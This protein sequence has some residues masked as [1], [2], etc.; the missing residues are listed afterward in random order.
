[1]RGVSARARRLT[2]STRPSRS[3]DRGSTHVGAEGEAAGAGPLPRRVHQRPR[4]AAPGQDGQPVQGER[5]DDGVPGDAQDADQDLPLRREGAEFGRDVGEEEADEEARAGH[6]A[7]DEQR[8]NDGEVRPVLGQRL[9]Q[10]P[11]V[12]HQGV[13]DLAE[14]AEAGELDAPQRVARPAEGG[15]RQRANRVVAGE[16]RDVVEEDEEVEFLRLRQ[17]RVPRGHAVPQNVPQE[18]REGGGDAH[19]L[20]ERVVLHG[21]VRSVV[22]RPQQ[23]DGKRRHDAAVAVIGDEGRPRRQCVT[24]HASFF[25]GQHGAVQANEAPEEE[26]DPNLELVATVVPRCSPGIRHL[27]PLVCEVAEPHYWNVQ[28]DKSP[29]FASSR[30]S[31]ALQGILL[32]FCMMYEHYLIILRKTLG[33]VDVDCPP[34]L[35]LPHSARTSWQACSVFAAPRYRSQLPA[36]VLEGRWDLLCM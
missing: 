17:R 19:F 36:L 25:Q 10:P 23:V 34:R 29:P 5:Q 12:V 4:R 27:K 18:V 16:H 6:E 24:Q 3:R 7:R 33:F 28:A 20:P 22:V 26:Q 32:T 35:A 31:R 2:P 1:M 11:A 8:R 15:A 14:V 13:G 30:D 9:R 21:L